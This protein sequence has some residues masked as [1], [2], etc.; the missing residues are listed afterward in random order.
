VKVLLLDAERSALIQ[1][2]RLLEEQHGVT[3][4]GAF[5]NPEQAVKQAEALQ[6]DVVF[7]DIH[8]PTISGLQAA[9]MIQNVCPDSEIAFLTS[10]DQHALQAFELNA[11]DYLLKP[12]VRGRLEKTLQHLKKRLG[13]SGRPNE[14]QPQTARVLC[15]Q[16]IRFQRAGGVP[17]VPKW[18]TGKAQELFAYLLHRRGEVVRKEALLGLLWPELDEKRAMAQLYTAVYQI[19]QCLSNMEID[20]SIRNSRIQEGYALETG[21]VSLDIVEWEREVE[22]SAKKLPDTTQELGSLLREYAGDYLQDHGYWWAEQERERLCRLWL[23]AARLLVRAHEETQGSLDVR[24]E[25]HE[26]MQEIDPYHEQEALDLLRLYEEAGRHD[27]VL[28]RFQYMERMFTHELGVEVPDS[29]LN[30]FANW[31][32]QT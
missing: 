21:R 20:I 2:Q 14:T 5:Q 28:D 15:L 27:Q 12:L 16:S 11:L 8:L 10:D 22:E 30:W 17:E 7:L 32:S 18:R 13:P 19:R 4:V 29:L 31:K 24:I 23:K 1:T 9:E 25:L 3:V 26:R 6:P